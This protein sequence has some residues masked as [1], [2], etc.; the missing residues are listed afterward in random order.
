M[1][2]AV[3]SGA[4]V[5][6]KLYVPKL[7]KVI[8]TERMTE[9]EKWF[10]IAM[11]DGSPL[12]HGPGQFA[13]VSVFGLGE[14][15][16]SICSSP[17]QG[18][19]FEMCVRAVGEVT[20][21]LHTLRE[22]DTVGI[23]G[24]FGKGFDVQ[25]MKGADVL[26]VAGGLGLA[27]ARSLIQYVLDRRSDFGNVTVFYGARNPKEMLFK[28]DVEEWLARADVECLVT[29]D[30]G[31]ETWKG[32]VGVIT[33]LFP[34]VKLN[35]ARTWAVIVGPPIMYK[36]A[37]L[38]ALS[39]GIPENRILCSLER[40]MKCGLGKCGHCQINGIYVCQEGP[41]F[42]YSQIKRLREAI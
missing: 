34:K 19:S 8:H 26:F 13:E 24:P 12:G 7:A 11:V 2:M 9:K 41:V 35:G 16:I 39:L 36:F 30:R 29:V 25:A 4:G 14:A 31:D 1:A 28:S 32:N 15:P 21:R 42:S 40:R 22:G 23:R 33:T 6:E 3:A 17:T 37:V 27:P 20:Q 5:G 10:R 18:S 38:E